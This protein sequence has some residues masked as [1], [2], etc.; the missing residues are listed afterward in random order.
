MARAINH[1]E[2]MSFPQTLRDVLR[3]K[4]QGGKSMN[5]VVRFEMPYDNRERMAKFY[6]SV[7]GWRTEMLGEAMDKYVV[8]TPP[9]RATIIA[10]RSQAQLTA[11]L[12]QEGRLASAISIRRHC[13]GRHRGRG[14]ESQAGRRPH[15]GRANGNSRHRRICV[16]YR[17]RRQSR[18]H[19]ATAVRHQA[20]A[21]K[22]IGQSPIKTGNR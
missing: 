16:V 11:V 18:R 2:H 17:H 5:P 10:E 21:E 22:A 15:P 1:S 13:G 14:Q 20:D 19:A 6:G 12:R 3:V 8:A 9:Q 4:L 7:F